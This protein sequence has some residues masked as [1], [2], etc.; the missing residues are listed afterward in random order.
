MERFQTCFYQ[1]SNNGRLSV[2][3]FKVRA[4]RDQKFGIR[5]QEGPKMKYS[6][7][8]KTMF[9]YS[10]VRPPIFQSNAAT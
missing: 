4:G 10:D 1:K 5:L 3:L 7:G 8:L 9:D 2:H 6:L